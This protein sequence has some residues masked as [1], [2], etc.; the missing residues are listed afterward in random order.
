MQCCSQSTLVQFCIA[1][2]LKK[3]FKKFFKTLGLSRWP[4]EVVALPL[5]WSWSSTWWSPV[6]MVVFFL[7]WIFW[8][9][10]VHLLCKTMTGSGWANHTHHRTS[11]ECSHIVCVPKEVTLINNGYTISFTDCSTTFT[12]DR[13]LDNIFRLGEIHQVFPTVI[14]N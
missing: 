12:Q 14:E 5:K 11:Q 13:H 1:L 2:T 7:K 9:M 10:Y 8:V 3:F 4:G 6:P